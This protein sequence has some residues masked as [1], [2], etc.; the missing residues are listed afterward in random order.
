MP[1]GPSVPEG[2]VT[3]NPGSFYQRS[4]AAGAGALYVKASG[5]GNTGWMLVS[6][7][8]PPAATTVVSD[9]FTRAD[10]TSGLGVATSGQTWTVVTGSWGISSNEAYSPSH[11]GNER[12]I[13]DA[14]YSDVTI[15]A[16]I[17]AAPASHDPGLLG[18]VVTNAT[19]PNFA[20]GLQVLATSIWSFNS[21]GLGTQV[22]SWTTG[23]AA[24]DTVRL[25]LAGSAVTVLIDYGTIGTFVQKTTIT[26]TTNQTATKHGLRMGGNSTG[27]LRI[28]NFTIQTDL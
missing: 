20:T 23:F 7:T 4:S 15:T 16:K 18:R 19:G 8:A 13:I 28:D 10:T 22:G 14:G 25:I 3:A 27:A 9:T 6:T 11:F 2:A 5:V 17:T 26:D 12:A 24:G 1:S 21:A